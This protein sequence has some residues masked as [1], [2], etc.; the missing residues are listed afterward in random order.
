MTRKPDPNAAQTG[1]DKE[2][3]AAAE[4]SQGA[5]R[6]TDIIG[7]A[8]GNLAAAAE[9]G[10]ILREGLQQLA[11]SYVADGQA[12]FAALSADLRQ[13]ATAKSPAELISLQTQF[14]RR[15]CEAAF[16]IGTQH[17]EALKQIAE[18]ASAP[19]AKQLKTVMGRV[20]K[21]S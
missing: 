12:L 13:L 10:K 4:P 20:R 7:L 8:K 14:F 5:E 6:A 2:A 18:D 3:Q 17:G 21:P 1:A 9:S 19:V 16:T 15:N 11:G